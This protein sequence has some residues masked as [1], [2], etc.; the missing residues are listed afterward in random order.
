MRDCYRQNRVVVK[1]MDT[2][3]GQCPVRITA[4]NLHV[5][6]NTTHILTYI[7]KYPR[8]LGHVSLLT[9]FLEAFSKD[10]LEMTQL[11]EQE[12]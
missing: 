7:H 3:L 12:T 4:R 8:I 2:M 1:E 5:R 6:R 9:M 10:L 11:R